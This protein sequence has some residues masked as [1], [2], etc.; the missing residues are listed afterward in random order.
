MADIAVANLIV[1]VSDD[2]REMEQKV[3]LRDLLI[4]SVMLDTRIGSLNGTC[5]CVCISDCTCDPS[6]SWQ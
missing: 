3:N 2:K 4:S 1:N 6:C 5:A